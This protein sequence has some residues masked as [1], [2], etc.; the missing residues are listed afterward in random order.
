MISD[1]EIADI[2]T[3]APTPQQAL[4][5]MVAVANQKGGDDNITAVLVFMGES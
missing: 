5:R 4:E 2:L 3:F 1:E